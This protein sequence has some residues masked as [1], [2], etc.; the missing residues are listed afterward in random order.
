MVRP[1]DG[2]H[3]QALSYVSLDPSSISVVLN[4]NNI[5]SQLVIT[6]NATN[7][8]VSFSGLLANQSYEMQITVSNAAGVC[9]Y[10]WPFLYD[11]RSAHAV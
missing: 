2:I 7:R 8:S 6:G 10:Q 5:S 4:S 1:G 3:F 9:L 11:R